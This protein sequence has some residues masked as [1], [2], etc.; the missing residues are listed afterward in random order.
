MTSPRSSGGT[1][2]IATAS[3]SLSNH[4]K[5]RTATLKSASPFPSSPH[6]RSSASM[7]AGP[8]AL[9]PHHAPM[10]AAASPSASTAASITST[11]SGSRNPH[12][13]L[14]KILLP[15]KISAA[16]AAQD[17]SATPLFTTSSA[18]ATDASIHSITLVAKRSNATTAAVKCSSLVSSILL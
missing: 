17:S 1:S 2:T 9:R 15:S 12:S 4:H 14:G 6:A 7:T 16:P 8:T 18:F 3:F 11:Q 13:T 5:S 10:T